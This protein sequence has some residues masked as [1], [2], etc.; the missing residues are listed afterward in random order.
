MAPTQRILFVARFHKIPRLYRQFTC[1]CCFIAHRVWKSCHSTF[2]LR[3]TIN[4]P[5]LL[6]CPVH[7]TIYRDITLMSAV[8]CPASFRQSQRI[9]VD[10]S[11]EH[12]SELQSHLNIVCRLLLEKKKKYTSAVI[13]GLLR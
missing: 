1:R 12:T 4:S 5:P 6:Q 9:G 7:H 8:E 13:Y 11:E 3:F 2:L 10:R